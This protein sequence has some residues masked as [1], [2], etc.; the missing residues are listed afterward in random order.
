MAEETI[1]TSPIFTEMVLPFILIFTVVFAILQKTQILGKG[2][3]QID[4]IVSLA[5]GLMV[6]SYANAVGIISDLMPFMAVSVVIILVFLLLYGMVFKEGEFDLSKKVKNVFGGLAAL[7]VIIAVVMVTGIWGYI[8]EN[9]LGGESQSAI[10][11]NTIFII[12]IAVAI[13]IVLS[14]SKKNEDSD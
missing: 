12:I 7:A 9:W 13:G 11:T 2:K 14:S 10:V 6:V 4:A 5:I 1:L 3:K 8:Q